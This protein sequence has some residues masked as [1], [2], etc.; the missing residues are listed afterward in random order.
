MISLEKSLNNIKNIGIY[1]F[2]SISKTVAAADKVNKFSDLNIF[3]IL[4]LGKSSTIIISGEKN[5]LLN[6][7]RE[8]IPTNTEIIENINIKVI[9]AYLSLEN[10]NIKKYFIC[11]ESMWLGELFHY[12]NL[13]V[14]N[15][16]EFVDFRFPRYE[17]SV[18]Y[19][20]MTSDIADLELCSVQLSKIEHTI[21]ENPSNKIKDFYNINI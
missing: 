11:V 6:L 4:E 14:N 2:S 1:Q 8:T 17:K 19:I 10:S 13:L 20:L 21:I 15:Q 16:W 18:G 9:N 5:S 3:E 12:A 7:A